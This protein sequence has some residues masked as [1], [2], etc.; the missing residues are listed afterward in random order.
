MVKGVC[1]VLAQTDFPGLTGSEIDSLL[2]MVRVDQRET[3]A[4]KR[5]S[6]Y[7]TL[8]NVQARQQAGNVVGAFIARAMSPGRYVTQPNRFNDL[9]DRLKEFLVFYG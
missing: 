5:E 6:L 9:R 2:R 3:G 4:N 1:D 7:V 8:H